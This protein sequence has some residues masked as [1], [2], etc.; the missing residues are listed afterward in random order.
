MPASTVPT[1]PW[2]ALALGARLWIVGGST[3]SARGIRPTAP[4]QHG[5]DWRQR[6]DAARRDGGYV[7]L[8]W[9]TGYSKNRMYI[10]INLLGEQQQP[11][12]RRPKNC[13][14]PRFRVPVGEGCPGR[15]RPFYRASEKSDWKTA[16][17][18]RKP[19]ADRRICS[20]LYGAKDNFY[21]L[22]MGFASSLR[23]GHRPFSA[24]LALPSAVFGPVDSPPCRGQRPE[25]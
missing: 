17:F 5:G 22:P 24:T 21:Q 12:H 3:A 9:V 2:L 11:P 8:P 6:H 19:L 14:N 20:H 13:R 4:I 25:S 23:F 1:A 16:E 15:T 7:V 18:S 10:K